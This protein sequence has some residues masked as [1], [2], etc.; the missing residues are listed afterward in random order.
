[1][2]KRS[3][4]LILVLALIFICAPAYATEANGQGGMVARNGELAAFLDGNGSIYISG[5]DTP[6]NATPAASILTI[7]SYRILFL[8]RANSAAGIPST[9]LVSLNLGDNAETIVTDDA[10]AACLDGETVYYVSSADRTKLMR[11]DLDTRASSLAFQS[12][13]VLQRVYPSSNGVIVTLVEGAGAYIYDSV[14][15]SFVSFAGEV[16]SEIAS[17]EDFDLYLTD[18]HNLYVQEHGNLFSTQVDSSVQDWAVIGNTVYYLTGS[19]GNLTLKSYGVGNALWSVVLAPSAD[20]ETQLTASQNSLFMLS[21]S[22][23]VYSVDVKNGRL[24]GFA[25]LPSLSSY[26]LGN[27]KNLSAYRIEAVSGQL[28]VY[29]VV[30]D[31]DTLPTFTF[32]DFTSQIVAD[33]SSGVRLLSAY[34]INGESTVWDLLQ[35]A[36]QFSPLRRGSR[37]DAVAAIQQPLYDLNYYNYY[38]DGIFGWRTERAVKLLQADLGLPVTGVADEDLQRTIL[39]GGLEP[40]NPYKTLKRGSTGW[41]VQEMQQRLRDLGYLADSADAIFGPRTEKA[42]ALFQRENGLDDTG[43]ADFDTLRKLYSDSANACSTY[44]DL[45]RGDSGY[46]VRELNK[47]LKA[48]YYLDGE[49]GSYYN[50]E[51]VAAVKR[52]QQEVGLKQTGVATTAV[53]KELFKRGAPEYSGYITLRRGDDNE[54]VQDMQLRLTKLGYHSGRTDGYFDKTTQASVKKF[55]AAAGLPVTGV[56]DPETLAALFDPDAPIYHEPVKIGTPVI[57]LSAYSKFENDIYSIADSV[58]TDGGVTVSWY[59]EGDVASYD[60]TIADDQGKTYL[61]YQDIPV[62]TTIAS[63]PVTSL[64]PERTYTV[65]VAAYPIDAAGDTPTSSTLRFVRAVEDPEPDPGEIGVIGKLI[66]TP[67][68][69]DIV[70]ESGVYYIPGDTLSFKWSADGSVAGYSYAITDAEGGAVLQ[71]EGVDAE[72]Y[73]VD[74]EASMFTEG[75]TYTL[76]VYAVPTNG[77]IDDATVES[78]LFGRRAAIEATPEPTTDPTVPDSPDGTTAE[79]TEEATATPEPEATPNPEETATPAPETTEPTEPEETAAPEPVTVGSPVLAIEPS[80]GIVEAEITDA[81]G[82]VQ[83][84]S[85]VQVAGDQDL[86][87][88]FYPAEGDVFSYDVFIVD[89]HG[90]VIIDEYMIVDAD[91]FINSAFLTPGEIYRMDVTAHAAADDR[92]TATSTLYFTLYAPEATD[93]PD[94]AAD[95]AG[96]PAVISEPEAVSEPEVVEPV[97]IGNPVLG[98]EPNLGTTELDVGGF[99][100]PVYELSDGDIQFSW[101]AEGNIAGYNVRI[102]DANETEMVNQNLTD[103]GAGISSDYLTPE[104]I[105]S[106]NVTAYSSEDGSVTSNAVLYFRYVPAPAAEPETQEPVQEPEYAEPEDTEPEDT[107]PEDTEP[108]YTEPEYTEPEYTEPEYTEPEYTE[109]EYTEPEYTEPE[110]TEPEYEEPAEEPASYPTDDPSAWTEAIYPDSDP[111]AIRVIQQR[112]V[113]WKWLAKDSCEEGILDGATIQAIVDF[114]AICAEGG[115]DLIPCNPDDPSIEPDTL[116]LLFNANGDSYAN[117]NA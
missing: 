7:D 81:N 22:G 35:P 94:A 45:Q 110:D 64:D 42:V 103:T 62:D 116:A 39:A 100:A 6:V 14:R 52:F 86:L 91:T 8:A 78:I 59:A 113:E 17:F 77:T 92:V 108:E 70:R 85:V 71:S 31:A 1:M 63:I 79:P 101:F 32:V 50:S 84:V 25:T 66:V 38:I 37:G 23:T 87:H 75:D 3:I 80:L 58:T 95:A 106:L 72:L 5:L 73:G 98:V 48:L 36:P 47:R 34:S 69:E 10:Y 54:R 51:T 44:I 18:S 82:A 33:T 43:I 24:V 83:T 99:T 41:R 57:E 74:L 2:K 26:A 12:S 9:R 21:K 109:P 27:G 112:L 117:P 76:T 46:R 68:G 49:V 105:Y 56:A 67:E 107:E 115:I 28:N 93:A 20:M 53:Q 97:T 65:T 111:E 104:A 16:A 4:L 90:Q 19:A 13:E 60:V 29:G 15:Q 96:E 11:L 55:Q 89:S 114:Q 102:L 88:L 61:D 40:Y 30:D